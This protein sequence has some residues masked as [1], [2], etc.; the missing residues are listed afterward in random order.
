VDEFAPQIAWLNARKGRLDRVIAT[1]A[2]K[3]YEELCMR[4]PSA[5][6]D[7]AQTARELGNLGVGKDFCYDRPACGVAYSLWYHAR[8]VNGLFPVALRM[9][10]R[11]AGDELVV[12]DLGAGTGATQWAMALAWLAA[13]Q[14][15][16]AAP[17]T[18]RFVNVDSSPFM[19]RSLETSW[20]VLCSEYGELSPLA[21]AQYLNDWSVPPCSSVVSCLFASYLFD[22]Q[23]EFDNLQARF[24]ETTADIQPDTV[25]ISTSKQKAKFLTAIEGALFRQRSPSFV[26]DW[27]V[28]TFAPPLAGPLLHVNGLRLKLHLGGQAGWDELP[29]RTPRLSILRRRSERAIDDRTRDLL[30]SEP[31]ALSLC[32]PRKVKRSDVK[33]SREQVAASKPDGFPTVIFGPAGCG[34]SV[35]ITERVKRIVEESADPLNLRILLTTFNKGLPRQILQPWLQD[36]L[37]P[38][39]VQWLPHGNDLEPA[40]WSAR[41]PGASESFL[42]VMHFDVLPTQLGLLHKLEL[43]HTKVVHGDQLRALSQEVAASAADVLKHKTFND[44]PFQKR[45]YERFLE[46]DF[47]LE[48]YQRVFYGLGHHSRER[49]LQ[50]P[51]HGRPRLD[52]EG[53][54]RSALWEL[55]ADLDRRAGAMARRFPAATTF[56]ARR[57]RFLQLLGGGETYFRELASSHPHLPLQWALSGK[58]R[59]MTATRRAPWEHRG[60]FTHLLVDEVQDCTRTDFRLFDQLLADPHE[61]VVAGDLAQAV[62]MGLAATTT[63]PKSSRQKNRKTHELKGS[64]RLPLRVSES[65]IPLSRRIQDK[66]RPCKDGLPVSAQLPYRGAPVGARPIVLWAE[67]QEAMAKKVREVMS[68]YA[69]GDSEP[70]MQIAPAVVLERDSE[71]ARAINLGAPAGLGVTVQADTILSVKGME[72]GC[73]IWSTRQGDFDRNDVDEYVYTILT[74]T[75]CLLIIAMFPQPCPDFIPILKTFNPESLIFWDEAS[76]AGFERLGHSS[77]LQSSRVSE[78]EPHPVEGEPADQEAASGA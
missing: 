35:V 5:S 44:Q 67:S 37:R 58:G 53:R 11:Y 24:C 76:K 51:R 48:E 1:A 65:L 14:S 70:G 13:K 38:H 27:T 30:G 62:H 61:L 21:S 78:V 20:K 2:Q 47:L 32:N 68:L 49:F 77:E 36:L 39:S 57:H 18:L 64:Y 7:L 56:V 63:L 22:S 73:V 31:Q 17:A 52:R 55:V 43:P 45:D 75:C 16:M 71:L 3:A 28:S 15:R 33:L 8:R 66:R 60:F 6:F 9:V 72:K 46:G 26:S 19:L 4:T 10:Q 59:F 74:R 69:A 25:V 54:P 42:Y 34:K 40:A 50:E 29:D 12:Y 23:E 41:F